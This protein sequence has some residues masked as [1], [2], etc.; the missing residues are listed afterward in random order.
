M[1][2]WLWSFKDYLKVYA[3][4]LGKSGRWVEAEASADPCLSMCA[5]IANRVKHGNLRESRSGKYAQLGK[6]TYSVPQEAMGKITVRAFEVELDVSNS[7]LVTF[8]MPVLE[9]SG[10]AIGDAFKFLERG[11]VRWE[12]LLSEIESA[13]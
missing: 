3:Q 12:E 6:L 10:R 11:I 2:V 9:G 1:F 7:S 4:S 13:V 5:D 8:E